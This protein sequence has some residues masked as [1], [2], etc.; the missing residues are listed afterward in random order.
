[1]SA[2]T[3]SR[4]GGGGN[5]RA[6]DNSA[7]SHEDRQSVLV[8]FSLSTCCPCKRKALDRE[9][10]GLSVVCCMA[11]PCLHIVFCPSC[12]HLGRMHAHAAAAPKKTITVMSISPHN[13]SF[14]PRSDSPIARVSRQTI[15][16]NAARGR[17]MIDPFRKERRLNMGVLLTVK[18]FERTMCCH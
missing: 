6:A 17:I 3:S 5:N 8:I 7:E 13:G 16:V 10:A 14:T 1:M 4:P 12:C 15:V 2:A 18:W 11:V 9:G